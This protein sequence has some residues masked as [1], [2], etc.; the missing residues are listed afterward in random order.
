MG[1]GRRVRSGGPVCLAPSCRA[2]LPRPSSTLRPRGSPMAFTMLTGNRLSDGAVVYLTAAQ[3]WSERLED[4]Q[5]AESEAEAARLEAGGREAVRLRLVVAPYLIEVERTAAGV[6]PVR[7]RELIRANGP[8]V[9]AGVPHA[10][11]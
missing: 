9:P 8:S 10:G 5:L 4:G 6:E 3:E 11:G 2:S 1:R 7:Y